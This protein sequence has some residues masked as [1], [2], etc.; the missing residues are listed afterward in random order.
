M[1]NS[2]EK[3][4]A[5]EEGAPTS[6]IQRTNKKETE[7]DDLKRYLEE[8]AEEFLYAGGIDKW[9][10]QHETKNP[11]RT[12]EELKKRLNEKADL[13]EGNSGLE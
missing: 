8:V 11:Q 4:G 13:H 3:S 1:G 12:P 10:P 6:G 7:Y 5:T 9:P 2:P